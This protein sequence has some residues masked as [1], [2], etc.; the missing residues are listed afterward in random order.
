MSLG[1]AI[2]RGWFLLLLILEMAP[3]SITQAERDPFH[4]WIPESIKTESDAAR[5]LGVIGNGRCW[6]VW[7][8]LPNRESVMS[9]PKFSPRVKDEDVKGE[10]H[11]EYSAIRR[12][13]VYPF[14]CAAESIGDGAK[15]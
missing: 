11:A 6:T 1:Q 13:T 4:S 9:V 5:V 10:G 8:L 7:L 15:E 2:R 3:I 12:P 14:G